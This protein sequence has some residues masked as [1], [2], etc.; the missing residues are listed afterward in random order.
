MCERTSATASARLLLL[1]RLPPPPRRTCPSGSRTCAQHHRSMPGSQQ[2]LGLVA[3]MP[4]QA[5]LLERRC[6]FLGSSSPRQRAPG[7]NTHVTKHT[8]PRG[9]FSR[10][11]TPPQCPAAHLTAHGA[12]RRGCRRCVSLLVGLGLRAV[13]GGG[14]PLARCALRRD[15]AARCALRPQRRARAAAAPPRR[16]VRL[17]IA[18]ARTRAALRRRHVVVRGAAGPLGRRQ[19]VS[20]PGVAPTLA[21]ALRRP[22]AAVPVRRALA[23]RRPLAAVPVSRAL[24]RGA[25]AHVAA[26]RCARVCQALLCR[27]ALP[28]GAAARQ[29]CGR[30]LHVPVCQHAARGRAQARREARPDACCACRAINSA[31]EEAGQAGSQH[32]CVGRERMRKKVPELEPRPAAH[33]AGRASGLPVSHRGRRAARG[34][35]PSVPCCNGLAKGTAHAGGSGPTS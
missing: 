32:Q 33:L 10:P 21:V 16:A 15:A 24:V 22:L 30:R 26:V 23:L 25:L 34:R 3:C 2:T 4:P 13:L 35:A 11:Q 6:P 7:H 27:A 17:T 12:A 29:R 20:L 19:H 1:V 18:G 9:S 28:G 14:A 5:S 31:P 8:Y